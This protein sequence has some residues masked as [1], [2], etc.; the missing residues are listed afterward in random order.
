M[1][2]FAR[3]SF[4]LCL[5][6]ALLLAGC[7]KKEDELTYPQVD[8]LEPTAGTRYDYGDTIHLSVKV[9]N[10]PDGLRI[11][12]T[13]PGSSTA[14]QPIDLRQTLRDDNRYIYELYYQFPYIE[15]GD[16]EIKVTA[17][18][19]DA[20]R[21]AF[22]QIKLQELPLSWQGM[23]SASGSLLYYTDEQLELELSYSSFGP[24]YPAMAVSS[25]YQQ[26][27]ISDTNRLELHFIDL[28]KAE[29]AFTWQS[30]GQEDI[31]KVQ[32][33]QG[34]FYVLTEDGQVSQLGESGQALFHYQTADQ[35]LAQDLA[36]NRNGLLVSAAQTVSGPRTLYYF[37][38]RQSAPLSQQVMNPYL[39]KLAPWRKDDFIL[40]ENRSS[41]IQLYHYRTQDHSIQRLA[42]IPNETA[43]KIAAGKEGGAFLLTDQNIYEI[44]PQHPQAPQQF[45]NFAPRDIVYNKV[46]NMLFYTH[47]KELGAL[48]AGTPTTLVRYGTSAHSLDLVYNK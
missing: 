36:I 29:L 6:V 21:S 42:L 35:G 28:R 46:N 38:D 18:N 20:F 8:I 25:K 2:R 17:S 32:E 13:G 31:I 15:T 30:Q 14:P 43:Q 39:L 5:L 4:P 27:A 1:A 12:L 11:S 26:V 48:I 23:V 22:R 33:W 10:A 7:Q 40:A 9:Q 41:G 19:G 44:S 45:A 3:Y 47:D 37:R 34:D 16:Y 24:Y